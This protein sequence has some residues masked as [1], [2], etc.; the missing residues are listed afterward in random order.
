MTSKELISLINSSEDPNEILKALLELVED[1]KNHSLETL[2]PCFNF[3]LIEPD[4]DQGSNDEIHNRPIN[5]L[6]KSQGP[7]CNNFVVRTGENENLVFSDDWDEDEDRPCLRISI[8]PN[9][10]PVT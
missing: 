4:E 7:G 2:S 3:L 1:S 9:W 8:F 5:L 10:K 6:F